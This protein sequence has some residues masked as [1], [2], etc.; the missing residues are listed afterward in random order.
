M[1]CWLSIPLTLV[2]AASV[3]CGGSD[4]DEA[5]ASTGGNGDGGQQGQTDA[6]PP[7]APAASNALGQPCTANPDNCP[8]GF[9]CVAVGASGNLGCTKECPSAGVPCDGYSGPGVALCTVGVYTTPPP[10]P[11]NPPPPDLWACGVVC[12]D[13]TG[14]VCGT[15]DTCDGTCPGNLVCTPTATA[16]VSACQ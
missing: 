16:G 1:R 3:A 6:A 7:D 12:Q 4:G 11:A 15:E 2:V 10:D 9:F 13:T 5:D 14:Q 8:D